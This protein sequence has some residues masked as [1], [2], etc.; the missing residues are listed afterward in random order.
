MTDTSADTRTIVTLPCPLCDEKITGPEGGVGSAPFK[1][2]SHKYRIHGVRSTKGPKGPKG[3]TLQTDD[4]IGARPVVGIL[5]DARDQIPEGT[6][7]PTQVD[8]TKALGRGLGL[9]S[10]AVASYAVES[11]EYLTEAER[12]VVA[13]EL[14]L[15]PKQAEDI[16][17]PIAKAFAPTKLNRKYGRQV[18]ENVDVIGSIAELATLG[19]NW[20]NYLRTRSTH[21]GRAPVSIDATA[22]VVTPG[23]GVGPPAGPGPA[24]R[25]VDG[26]PPRGD[27][28][29]MTSPAPSSGVVVDADMVQAMQ[30]NGRG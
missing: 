29:P 14:S 2:A 16:M 22:V 11:D 7:P 27:G 26:R 17:R 8:L 19:L 15:T 12:D 4:E 6:A 5:Q 25:A 9:T 23:G 10:A 1:L 20:R 18:V 30:R 28:R 13:D 21:H 24:G 3:R